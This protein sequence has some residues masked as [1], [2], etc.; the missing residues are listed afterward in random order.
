MSFAN[1]APT[2]ERYY[3]FT[4]VYLLAEDLKS[5]CQ[6][7]RNYVTTGKADLTWLEGVGAGRGARGWRQV[8]DSW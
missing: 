5:V 2:S 1:H 3:N 4:G 6:L 7:T 8:A